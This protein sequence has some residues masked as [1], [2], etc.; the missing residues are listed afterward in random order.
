M[1]IVKTS[2]KLRT[3]GLVLCAAMFSLGLVACE[4][5]SVT[6]AA[7]ETQPMVDLSPRERIEG[8]HM[9]MHHG[10]AMVAEG[11]DLVMISQLGVEPNMDDKG[12]QH[13][14][15]IVASGRDLIEEALVVN[16]SLGE[17][18]NQPLVD[19]TSEL[20]ES[21]L[22]VTDVLDN[23]EAPELSSEA[24]ALHH[25]H[26]MLNHAL[27]MAADGAS[28]RMLGT[29]ERDVAVAQLG[30]RHGEQMLANANEMVEQVLTGPSMDNA[31]TLG[32]VGDPMRT[33]HMLADS[34][35]AVIA[36][37]EQMPASPSV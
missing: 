15:A 14:R 30:G 6:V 34:V 8:V 22:A 1:T 12:I 21:Y 36:L 3:P 37:M 31:H 10:L 20:G 28:L 11:A 16:Q 2:N 26:M 35:K 23:M 27:R 24:A 25:M 4:P 7:D 9:L 13:G 5:R 33:T 19:F 17:I 29:H 32:L 18:A